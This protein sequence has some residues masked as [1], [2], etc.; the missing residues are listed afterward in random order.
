MDTGKQ[1]VFKFK[2]SRSLIRVDSIGK[3]LFI[4]SFKYQ[5]IFV[6]ESF[7]YATK[8]RDRNQE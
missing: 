6:Q 5:N 4:G 3:L 1:Y 2:E 8:Y 7:S